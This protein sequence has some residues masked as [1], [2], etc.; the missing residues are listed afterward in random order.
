MNTNILYGSFTSD[1]NN[2]V[3]DLGVEVQWMEVWNAN[4]INST[5]INR[6]VYYYW[7]SNMGSSAFAYFHD[8]ASSSIGSKTITNAFNQ[9]DT[10][11]YSIGSKI[12]VTAGTNSTDPR[13]S[14]GDTTG[15]SNGGI[16]RLTGTDQVNL[17]GLDFSVDEV[18]ADTRFDLANTLATAPGIVAGASGYWRLVAPNR[19]VYDIIF[20][21]KRVVANITQATSAVVTTLVDHGYSVNQR[22]RFKVPKYSGMVELDGQVGTITAVSTSTFTVN[23][24]T[25]TYS[26][27]TF[28]E[29]DSPEW[30]PA[31]VVPIGE[32][33][34][35]TYDGRQRNSSFRGVVLTAGTIAP[36]GSADDVI[37]WRAGKA[38]AQ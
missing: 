1:G 16:V 33:G 15:L 24:D 9:V 36:G 25:S 17:H 30:T 21:A 29:Y 4:E 19:E 18:T 10:F 38:A 27:F 35:L 8:A 11:N 23:I 5:T 3:L 28:P 14:T 22:V 13:Y 12:A 37:R 26:A 32:E 6:G 20:P 2:K 7:D 34:T 31:Q